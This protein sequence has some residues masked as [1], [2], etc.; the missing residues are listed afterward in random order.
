MV[1]RLRRTIHNS[2]KGHPKYNWKEWEIIPS[3]GDKQLNRTQ[4]ITQRKR[5]LSPKLRRTKK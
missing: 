1:E 2:H 3:K 4:K 5:S